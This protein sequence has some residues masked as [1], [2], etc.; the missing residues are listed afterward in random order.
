MQIAACLDHRL[1][2]PPSPAEPP[3]PHCLRYLSSHDYPLE[4]YHVP[5][6][7]HLLSQRHYLP[8]EA[9]D[10]LLVS[11]ELAFDLLGRNQVNLPALLDVPLHLHYLI[12]ELRFVRRI[13]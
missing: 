4:M 13:R 8:W 2:S 10:T 9:A 7:L 3:H 12:A 1:P 6:Y 5:Q 11:W